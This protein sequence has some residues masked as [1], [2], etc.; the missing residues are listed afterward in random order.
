MKFVVTAA[1]QETEVVCSITGILSLTGAQVPTATW[2]ISLAR[3]SLGR[4]WT[5]S[6][7]L[8]PLP[9][10]P[11]N[12]SFPSASVPFPKLTDSLFF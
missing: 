12:A 5:S 1:G 11:L 4:C 3:T 2:E 7:L 8:H 6:L 9:S 10:P